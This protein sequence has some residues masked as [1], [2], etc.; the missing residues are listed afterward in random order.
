VYGMSDLVMATITE[1]VTPHR[2]ST[3]I[4]QLT[5]ASRVKVESNEEVIT[6]LSDD[7]LE[8]SP[9]VTPPNR[10]P[11]VDSS[12]QDSFERTHTPIC[13]PPPH[14]GHQLSLSVVESLKRL[15]ASK[16]VRNVFKSLDYVRS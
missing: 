10:I 13:R 3:G 8:N 4:V 5:S 9:A 7:S 15:Q 12:L 14:C 11:L 1:L 6:I 2:S 16:G